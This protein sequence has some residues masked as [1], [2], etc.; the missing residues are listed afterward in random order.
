MD[1]RRWSE[2]CFLVG[3][4][5]EVCLR[6]AYGIVQ[7]SRGIC[8]RIGRISTYWFHTE[9]VVHSTFINKPLI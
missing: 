3:M 8:S 4:T 6:V 9:L 7:A 1:G 2:L 5:I